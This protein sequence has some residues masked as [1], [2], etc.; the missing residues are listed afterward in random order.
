[1]PIYVVTLARPELIERR[2]S[3]A[4]A[5]A[6]SC[7]SLSS[8]WPTPDMRELLAGLVPGLPDEAVAAI[9]ARADGIPLYAVETVRT[10][11]ADGPARRCEDGVYAPRA[12]ST[13]LAVPET[14]TALIAA[15]LDSL[16]AD[17]PAHRP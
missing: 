2:P 1:M 9:V 17:R 6:T 5:S 4:P 14:L 7:R 16:D 11:V 10:L 8:R 3:G 13:N 12:T 15:R